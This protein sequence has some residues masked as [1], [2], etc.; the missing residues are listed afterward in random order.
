[1]ELIS[2]GEADRKVNGMS[3]SDKYHKESRN[4]ARGTEVL[5]DYNL[6]EVIR[7]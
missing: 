2:S 4:S 5:R 7:K 6:D 1:M 3:E